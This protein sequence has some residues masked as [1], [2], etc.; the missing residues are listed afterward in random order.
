MFSRSSNRN[1]VRTNQV[2]E[3][4][5]GLLLLHKPAGKT[6]FQCVQAVKRAL[7]ADRAGH[8]GTLDPAATGLLIILLGKSTRDQ[9]KF[10]SLPKTYLFRA[11][12]GVQTDTA[13]MEGQVTKSSPADHVT[14]S[15]MADAMQS[16]QGD[17]QQLPPMYAALKYKGKPYYEYARKGIEIPRVPRSI[18][19]SA[20]ELLS[21]SAPEWEARVTCSRGTYVRTLVEDI[22]AKLGTCAV[23]VNLVRESIG[24]YSLAQALRWEDLA[25][26]RESLQGIAHA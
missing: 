15:A 14:Q 11:R 6:S 9:E 23:L 5:D 13:D 18:H 26:A 17:S 7:D 10:L 1:A 25:L 2:P 20:F 4:I 16:F 22:G 21:F 12:L 3:T 19:V 24:P 8:C